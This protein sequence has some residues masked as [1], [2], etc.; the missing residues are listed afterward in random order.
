MTETHHIKLLNLLKSIFLFI[1]FF[2]LPAFA[3]DTVQS[4]NSKEKN[5]VAETEETKKIKDLNNILTTIAEL[6]TSIKD[7]SSTLGKSGSKS[8]DADLEIEFK[9]RND[10]L[11]KLRTNLDEIA[12]GVDL[13]SYE[14]L[15]SEKTVD[16][17]KE[18]QEL[19]NPLLNEI[20]RLTNRPRELDRLYRRIAALKTS[21]HKSEDAIKNLKKLHEIKTSKELATEIENL[22]TSWTE[23]KNESIAEIS[24]SEQRL[25]QLQAESTSISSSLKQIPH[26]FFRSRVRNLIVACLST[27]I[28]WWLIRKSYRRLIKTAIMTTNELSDYRRII[29]LIYLTFSGSGSLIIYLFV[30]FLLGDWVLLILS[31]MLL[32]GIAWTS[33]HAFP[34][35][36]NQGA[37]LL[38]VGPVRE[39][40]MIIYNN[41]CWE[42]VSLNI[43]AVLRNPELQ[44]ETIRIPLNDLFSLR[45]RVRGIGEV[46]FPSK[47]GQWI[48]MSDSSYAQVINQ[49]PSH[50]TV[51]LPGGSLKTMS[52]DLYVSLA[53]QLLSSGFRITSKFGLDYRHQNEITTEIPKLLTKELKEDLD[54]RFGSNSYR[55]SVEL[56]SASSSSLD[57]LV[58][59]DVDGKFAE[60]YQALGRLVQKLSVQA[61]NKYKWSI[62]YSQL[63]VH[64]EKTKSLSNLS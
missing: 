16:W 60:D 10:K 59:L 38:N 29:N 63:T 14:Q 15:N 21:V 25:G 54:K 39:S 22:L 49:S 37:L 6:E 26:L 13:S 55:I 50:V 17:S 34:R 52:T 23:R 31:F 5:M 27:F 4:N 8:V 56:D 53:P 24:V 12:S 32:F 46:W 11:K 41:I 44:P 35:F 28:F 40:E 7:F 58:N 61:C 18:V 43:F 47:I 20:K 51:Q 9:S 62:P 36:W 48:L 1:S 30:L 3:D 19:L 42:V 45:S 2:I 57:L 33:K 64:L